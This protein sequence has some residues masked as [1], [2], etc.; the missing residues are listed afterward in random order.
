[1]NIAQP[2]MGIQAAQR[3]S[4]FSRGEGLVLPWAVVSALV[5]LGAQGVLAQQWK[6]GSDDDFR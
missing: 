4:G 5:Q 1:M 3:Q 6:L 2:H